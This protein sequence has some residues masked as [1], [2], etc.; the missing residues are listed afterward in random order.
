MQSWESCGSL[1]SL[2]VRSGP[3]PL[4][5]VPLVG[6]ALGRTV[7]P[8]LSAG[9]SLV[10]GRTGVTRSV[11]FFCLNGSSQ[12]LRSLAD[13]NALQIFMGR[14]EVPGCGCACMPWFIYFKN[15]KEI[16]VLDWDV[17]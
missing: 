1:Q 4:A 7:Q 10:I 13:R 14:T 9:I 16:V 2:S 17:T 12:H 8:P 5:S 3:G 6:S 11:Q 15:K